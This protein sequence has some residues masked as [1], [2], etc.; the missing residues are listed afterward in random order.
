MLTKLI[1]AVAGLALA[2][3]LAA[4]PLQASDRA[5][6]DEAKAMA[7]KAAAL[8]KAEGP[9]KAFPAFD[10]DAQFKDRDLYVF[11]IDPSGT[12]VAHGA[13]K[14][15]IGKSLLELRDPTGKQFVKEMISIPGTGW[16]DYSWQNPTTKA[17]EAKRSYVI[18]ESGYWVGVGAYVK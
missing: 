1:G 7:E 2:L 17:V 6:L 8:L 5:S 14:G 16:V 12:T 15:L 3:V 18:H 11:V 9:E 10:E 4:A 13:N